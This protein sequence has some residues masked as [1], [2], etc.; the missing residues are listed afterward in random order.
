LQRCVSEVTNALESVEPANVNRAVEGFVDELSNWYVRRSRRRFWKSDSDVDKANAYRTLHHVLLT[1]CQL[2]APVLPFSAEHLY[3][4]LSSTN[5]DAQESVH[6]CAWPLV[7]ESL[8]DDDLTREVEG[9]LQA[10]SLGNAARRESKVRNRQPLSRALIQAP[11]AQGRAA[12]EA[13]RETILDELNVKNIELLDDAGDLV[14]YNLKANLPV[15]GKKFGKQVGALRKK[16]EGAD[17][18]EA[19]RIGELMRQNQNVSL[20][21]DGETVT[22]APED[23]LVSTQQQ[24]GYSFA[25]EGGWS[26]ALDTT[27]NDELLV[28]GMARDFVRAVQESRKRADFEVSDR[29][30]ICWSTR[31]ANR[32]C[33]TF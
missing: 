1:L 25:S 7:D 3:R 23:V 10:V 13:W 2:V 14:T 27:L 24:S 8:R 18:T 11:D 6:L 5:A 19:K 29:I 32:V 31:Q 22:L 21:L 15:V 4:N 12:I 26:V 28:E 9:V 20:E 33:P 16:L 17:A 30:G